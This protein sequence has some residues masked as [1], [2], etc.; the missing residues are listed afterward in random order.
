MKYQTDTQGE[1]RDRLPLAT[2][3]LQ[4]RVVS[5][6]PE[7]TNANGRYSYRTETLIDVTECEYG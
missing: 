3:K 6:S 1:M 5:F 4:H 2:A 7:Q